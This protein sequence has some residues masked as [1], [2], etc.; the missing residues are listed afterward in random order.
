MVIH[1]PLKT[2]QVSVTGGTATTR[3]LPPGEPIGM[4][5]VK[6]SLNPESKTTV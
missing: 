5:F 4:P 2:L 6:V 3:T 1:A